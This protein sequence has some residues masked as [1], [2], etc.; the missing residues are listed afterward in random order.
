MEIDDQT[1]DNQKE[2]K[3]QIIEKEL[4][5]QIK[6]VAQEKKVNPQTQIET[7]DKN[8]IK[9]TSF[10]ELLDICILKRR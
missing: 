5:N 3:S 2:I 7:E 8:E 4:I 10:N 1:S 9:I 6:N